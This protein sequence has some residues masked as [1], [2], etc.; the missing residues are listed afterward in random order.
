VHSRYLPVLA[1]L[2]CGCNAM[3]SHQRGLLKPS[4]AAD[5]NAAIVWGEAVDGLRSRI[6]TDKERFNPEEPITVHYAIQNVGN[7]ARTVW[8]RGFEANNRIDV[9]TEDGK[10][11]HFIGN[12]SARSKTFPQRGN[13]EKNVPVVLQPGAIDDAY[14]AYNLRD[15]FDMKTPGVYSV[16]Y[17]HQDSED[18]KPVKSNELKITVAAPGS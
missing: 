5:M 11:A 13:W 4:G 18:E 16:Q 6:W 1:I 17:V 14:I 8:H 15:F 7:Q 12:A 3:D 9:R 2:F 10:P